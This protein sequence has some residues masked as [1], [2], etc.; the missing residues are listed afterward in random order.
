MDL[1]TNK[2]EIN[3]SNQKKRKIQSAN[4]AKQSANARALA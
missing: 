1:K 4:L 2:N 3:K